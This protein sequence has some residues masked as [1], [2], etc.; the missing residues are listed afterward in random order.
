MLKTK[1]SKSNLIQLNDSAS[2]GS[3]KM[4]T[5]IDES[6]ND[7]VQHIDNVQDFSFVQRVSRRQRISNVH[8]DIVELVLSHEECVPPGIDVGVI[9]SEANSSLNNVTGHSD[10]LSNFM[11]F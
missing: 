6:L 4:T 1:A 3:D 10:C 7:Y 2:F 9:D 11:I 5:S 8:V